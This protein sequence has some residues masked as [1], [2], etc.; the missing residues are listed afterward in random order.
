MAADPLMPT[1]LLTV[2]ELSAI[3]LTSRLASSLALIVDYGPTRINDLNELLA[4]VH[5][6]QHTI[7]AQAAARA[8]PDQFRL[9]G[10][11]R[12]IPR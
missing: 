6:I 11:P 3:T 7:M 10:H 4:H 8:Y 12:P 9:L 1:Q 2:E 5:A